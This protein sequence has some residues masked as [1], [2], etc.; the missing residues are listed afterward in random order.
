MNKLSALVVLLLAG[1]AVFLSPPPGASAP[2]VDKEAPEAR[3]WR[4]W[5]A[6]RR[7]AQI[8]RLHRYTA[9][10]VFPK[11]RD[12]PGELEPYF[13]DADET[14]CAV[15][16]L[17]IEAGELKLVQEIAARNNHVRVGAVKDGP[18]VD[19]ILASG[20]LQ[21]EAARVQPS[22]EFLKHRRPEDREGEREIARVRTHLR[23]VEKELI[24]GTG[25]ALDFAVGRLLERVARDPAFGRSLPGS[26]TSAGR[27]IL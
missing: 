17:M 2:L 9:R 11:N 22:Y 13:I 3:A 14:P 18:L 6:G 7:A 4:A 5:L 10:G 23:E 26:P 16:N 19:W 24:E 25:V 15:A 12:F 20:L 1:T 21:E 8:E 27:S